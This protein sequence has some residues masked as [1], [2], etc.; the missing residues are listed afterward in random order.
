V[1]ELTEVH[2]HLLTQDDFSDVRAV[3]AARLGGCWARLDDVISELV[4]LHEVPSEK[5]VERVHAAIA[6][7]DLR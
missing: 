5:I 2:H 3:L 1:P 6:D 4:A 7:E